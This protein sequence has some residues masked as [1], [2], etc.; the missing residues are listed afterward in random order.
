MSTRYLMDD[1][2]EGGRLT[3]K[4][5]S[6]RWVRDELTG[7]LTPGCRVLE[8]GCGPMHLVVAAKRTGAGAAFGVD[9]SRERLLA[10]DGDGAVGLAGVQARA[11]RLPFGNGHFDLVYT[12]FLLQYLADPG[13]A[14][15]EM[16]RVTRPGGTVVLQDLDSQ[17]VNHYPSDEAMESLLAE[18]LAAINGS[19][20]VFVGRKLFGLATE[21]GMSEVKVKVAA[22]HLIAGTP[23][24]GTMAGWELKLDIAYPRIVRALGD[25]KAREL[26]RR[27]LAY[28][29]D[30]ATLTYS[31][32]FTV[33]GRAPG[34][35]R[36]RTAA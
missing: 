16:C 18:F 34:T 35:A 20:D 9:V 27:F 32:I 28:L 21:A 10:A 8:V 6:G 29:A 11:E 4:V 7:Y 19:L 12:R 26:R 13:A 23:D 3:D 33:S 25:Q 30:P 14:V 1:S 17:L 5:D 2:R 15:A 31:T 22:Y 24:P 36:A